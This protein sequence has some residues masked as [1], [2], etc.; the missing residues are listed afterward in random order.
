MKWCNIMCYQMILILSGAVGHVLFFCFVFL[1]KNNKKAP[2]AH[3]ITCVV[4]RPELDVPDVTFYVSSLERAVLALA[5][6]SD[7][8]WCD[9]DKT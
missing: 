2:L 3:L 9:T 7:T 5:G 1:K 4:E 8:R 6:S